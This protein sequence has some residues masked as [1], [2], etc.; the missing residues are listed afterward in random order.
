[1]PVDVGNTFLLTLSQ[2]KQQ[3]SSVS[4]LSER[5]CNITE[6]LHRQFVCYHDRACITVNK[7]DTFIYS[8]TYIQVYPTRTACHCPK[9]QWLLHTTQ[10]DYTTVS[11]RH[12]TFIHYLLQPWTILTMVHFSVVDAHCPSSC[13][14]FYTTKFRKLG[15]FSS[16]GGNGSGKRLFWSACLKVL[17]FVTG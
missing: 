13:N 8:V 1:M 17:A 6:L 5:S 2:P 11:L 3:Q 4:H 15:M 12:P 10:Q 7:I 14:F 16:S 9:N